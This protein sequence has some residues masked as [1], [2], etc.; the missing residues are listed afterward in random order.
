MNVL[1]FVLIYAPVR[2][3]VCVSAW[4]LRF[5]CRTSPR[6]RGEDKPVNVCIVLAN[7][8]EQ[9]G[10]EYEGGGGVKETEGGRRGSVA[11][12]CCLIVLMVFKALA[13]EQML[14]CEMD[15]IFLP[16]DLIFLQAAGGIKSSSN[17]REKLMGRSI[18]ITSEAENQNVWVDF[19]AMY[20]VHRQ[21]DGLYQFAL[22]SIYQQWHLADEWVGPRCGCFHPHSTALTE[23]SLGRGE[24][25]ATQAWGE[26]NKTYVVVLLSSYANSFPFPYIT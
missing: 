21:E 23:T 25:R 19:T 10:R 11:I 26:C 4:I 22:Y 1:I 24:S 16:P 5:L 7:E 17:K 14:F 18:R 2:W 20:L 8:L 3:S 13:G 9:N 15:S 6:R 12:V